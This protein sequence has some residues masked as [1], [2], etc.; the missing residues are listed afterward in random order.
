MVYPL[1]AEQSSAKALHVNTLCLQR[2]PAQLYLPAGTEGVTNR[3][4]GSAQVTRQASS[5]AEHRTSLQRLLLSAVVSVTTT[6][7]YTVQNL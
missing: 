3:T 6:V 1:P 5:R 7:K 4:G 2:R